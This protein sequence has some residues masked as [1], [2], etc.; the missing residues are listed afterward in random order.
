MRI[1]LPDMPFYWR[2]KDR[3]EAEPGD[4]PGRLAF[5]FDYLDEMGLLI[6]ERSPK[7]SEILADIYMR[8]S[9]VGFLQE[10][11]SLAKGYGEDFWMFFQRV[12]SDFP[13][14]TIL[15]IGCGG[16]LLLARL[17]EIGKDVIG[18]DPSPV[19]AIAGDQK[20]VRV[21]QD[22]FPP[23]GFDLQPDLIFHVDVLEHIEDPV[24]FLELQREHLPPGKYLI[25]NVPDST[26]SISYGD[27]SMALHQHVNMFDDL[28]L[29]V[30]LKKAGFEVLKLEK[31]RFGASLYCLARNSAMQG[32]EACGLP[33]VK[34]DAFAT[35]AMANI[36]RFTHS[37]VR[38]RE[39]GESLGFFMPQRAFPYLAAA[40]LS[41]GFRVFDNMNTWHQKYFDGYS[42]PVE[43]EADVVVRP[44]DH[45][46]VMSLTFGNEVK[47]SLLTKLPR[48]KITTLEE[49]VCGGKA[50]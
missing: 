33:R 1:A 7:L 13:I 21:I 36:E 6:E 44:V 28:S 27:I 34:Y 43:N 40:G 35:K 49:I 18:V 29:T 15:E 26:R 24:R 10:G 23:R 17:Q 20:G 39:A 25:V 9:N 30:V 5:T 8:E 38:A 45:M 2:V 19:A 14:K 4:P 47:R 22:F 48:I 12:L 37:V 41:D 50:R 11:H 3:P 16:C 32:Q 42:S 31:S 46:Y